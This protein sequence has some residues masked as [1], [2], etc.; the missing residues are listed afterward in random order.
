MIT[1]K[2]KKQI[3]LIKSIKNKH[4]VKVIYLL[5][6]QPIGKRTEGTTKIGEQPRPEN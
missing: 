5:K 3:M 6:P 1:T 4:L 2:R